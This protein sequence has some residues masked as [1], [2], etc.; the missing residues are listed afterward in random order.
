MVRHDSAAQHPDPI[1]QTL[2]SLIQDML[3]DPTSMKRLED[4]FLDRMPST[5]PE[6]AA[7]VAAEFPRWREA[8]RPRPGLQPD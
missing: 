8:G 3:T 4:S 6:F 1:V 5:Q 2:H 7:F